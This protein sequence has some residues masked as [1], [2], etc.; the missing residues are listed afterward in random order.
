MLCVVYCMIYVY[1][2]IKTFFSIQSFFFFFINKNK[3]NKKKRVYA[4][5]E[6]DMVYDVNS[7]VFGSDRNVGQ[8]FQ[9][10]PLNINSGYDP[11]DFGEKDVKSPEMKKQIPF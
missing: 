10:F 5:K 6:P 4:Y 11:A 1:L 7:I 3:K 2:T 8:S 9:S